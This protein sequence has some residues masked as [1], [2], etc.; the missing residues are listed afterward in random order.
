MD[1]GTGYA[2]HSQS[3]RFFSVSP[4][5]FW[6]FQT[7][8]ARSSGYLEEFLYPSG[9]RL[10]RSRTL[11]PW[12]A[13]RQDC[14]GHASHT[15]AVRPKHSSGNTPVLAHRRCMRCMHWGDQPHMRLLASD[16]EPPS[17]LAQQLAAES[18]ANRNRFLGD[19]SRLDRDWR[20]GQQCI[21]FRDAYLVL[22]GLQAGECIETRSV[23][24]R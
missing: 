12:R 11:Y 5:L 18:S 14:A 1:I 3:C 22:A 13:D 8:L 24:Q 21:P 23:R 7:R 9:P 16:S 4:G 2:K 19:S 17:G 10:C 6:P 15:P 20:L